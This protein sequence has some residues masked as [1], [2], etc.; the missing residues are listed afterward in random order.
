MSHACRSL[1]LVAIVPR[2]HAPRVQEVLLARRSVITV[3]GSSPIILTMT[4]RR[5]ATVIVFE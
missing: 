4:T 2:A 3:E 1:E 5:N